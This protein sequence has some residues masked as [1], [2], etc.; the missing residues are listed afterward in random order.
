MQN[1]DACNAAIGTIRVVEIENGEMVRELLMCP[2]CAKIGAGSTKQTSLSKTAETIDALLGGA[3][4][5]P[6][7]AP[8]AQQ[9]VTCPGCKLTTTEFRLRGRLGC[10]RC[11]EVF[12][13]ALLP[14]LERIHDA[15]CHK[16][17]HPGL[18]A[19]A[20]PDQ[21]SVVELRNRLQNAI[22][23]ERYEDAARL[24]DE[25]DRVERDQNSN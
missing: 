5:E 21:D 23:E 14:L 20:A 13:P 17:R 4:A 11:Y 24:R 25:L 19:Q 8:S 12:R 1:C 10:P 7:M 2:P 3:V 16:G 15:T 6:P 18:A 22:A 9:E